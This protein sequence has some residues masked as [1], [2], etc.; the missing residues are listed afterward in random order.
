M[1]GAELHL[2][3]RRGATLREVASVPMTLRLGLLSTARINDAIVAAAGDVDEIEIVA[4]GSRDAGRAESYARERGI[5]AA[6]GSYEALLA[7]GEVDAVYI[8]LPNGLHHEWTLAALEAGKHVLCEKPYSR[9][10]SEVEEAFDLAERS[11][12]VLMEA[13]MFRHHPQAAKVKELVGEGAVG[14]VRVVRATF[15]FVLEDMEDV[16]MSAIL[17]GGSLMDLGCYCVSGARYLMGEPERVIGEQVVGP[18]G[19]DS[20]FHGTLRFPNDVVAQFDCS[21]ALPRY[22]RLDVVGDDGW[23]LVDAP[24]RTDWEG[25]LL[26]RHGDHLNRIEVPPADAY[27]LELANFAGAAAGNA[28]PL[29]SRSDAVGQARTIEALY[30]SAT[31]GRAVDL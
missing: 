10:P 13:F 20:A 8:P 25:E 31:E 14:R 27:A 28:E 19:V 17:D 29:L 23:L 11:R 12:L 6:H 24:W 26:L 9:R 18:T 16:R 7:D 30:L 4:V 22:Q 2:F 1:H 15:S 21:F 5:A 3:W